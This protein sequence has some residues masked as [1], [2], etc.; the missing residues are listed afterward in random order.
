MVITPRARTLGK[1]FNVNGELSIAQVLTLPGVFEENAE[2]IPEDFKQGAMNALDLAL[3]ALN[4]MRSTEG[5]ELKNE[6]ASRLEL[7]ETLRND[8]LPYT[9]NIENQLKAKLLEMHNVN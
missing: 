7:L 5:E 9:S 3:K 2:E 8:L 4:Q 1:E 6:L